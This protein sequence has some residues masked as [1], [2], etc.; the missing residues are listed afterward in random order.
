[1]KGVSSELKVGLFVIIAI[2]AMLYMTFRVENI[3]LFGEQK[4]NII[5]IYFD[6]IS[7]VDKK[8]QIRLAGVKIGTILDIILDNN[9]RV[10]VIANIDK[11]VKIREDS[12]A[13]IK[14]K[15]LLGEK[16][17][18]ITGGSEKAKFLKD[19]DT[20][21]NSKTPPDIDEAIANINA[22]LSD[23][24]AVT[25]SL[26]NVFGGEEGEKGIR[27]IFDNIKELSYNLNNIVIKSGKDVDRVMQNITELAQSL[28]D[29]IVSNRKAMEDIIAN[30]KDLS[31]GTKEKIPA[32]I[33]D[34][35]KVIM[36][37]QEIVKENRGDIKGF[38][39]NLKVVTNKI[40]GILDSINKI[41]NKI[42]KGEGT[43]GKLVTDKDVYEKLD[44]TLAGFNKFASKAEKLRIFVGFRDEYQSEEG[45]NKGYLSIKLR[46]RE[47]RYYL[48]EVSQDIR[49]NK[50]S[51]N[52]NAL[53]NL[54]Y[55]AE[56]H[57]RYS[58]LDLS[59]GLTESSVGLGA[60]Y[61]LMHDH[62]RLGFDMFNLSGYDNT[63][64]NLQLKFSSTL[65][66]Y[67]YLFINA[68]VDEILNR[69]YRSFFIGGG[70]MFDDEDLKTILSAL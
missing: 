38:M 65:N 49:K 12:V 32:L 45:E 52:N 34:I 18:E 17:I 7:G 67:K 35:D 8:A 57:K 46:P 42:E 39:E 48:L 64:D 56:F 36:E 47:D 63:V 10:K 23:I 41:A 31:S 37:I 62:I 5:Y 43:I 68:G 13:L 28:K 59:I 69:R 40:N 22:V 33:D 61:Y 50:K 11:D 70:I 26:K 14:A 6:S 3:S 16:Y 29:I 9:N 53:A 58:D 30:I 4:G 15:G 20:L 60:D 66:F 24:K 27:E 21:M 54:L 25:A 19:G 55:T 2:V 44:S 51:P 1:M